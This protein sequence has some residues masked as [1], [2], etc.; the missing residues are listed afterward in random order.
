MLRNI[1]AS[2]LLLTGVDLAGAQTFDSAN[3]LPADSAL[4]NFSILQLIDSLVQTPN[5]YGFG[6][7]LI[8]RLGFNSN[9][10]AASRTL[11]LS[12]FGLSPGISYYHKSGLYLDA[13]A[14][15]SQEYS[16][17]LYLT[18]PSAGYL[19]T[20]NK[21]T[22]N[23]EYSRY[24]YSFS[25]STYHLPYT[26]SIGMSNFYELKPF[27]FRFDYSLYFGEKTAHRLMPGIMLNFEK[28]NWH[29]LRRILFYPT[30]NVLLGNEKWQISQYI[31]NATTLS[32]ARALIAQHQPLFRI[33]TDSY[34]E[35]GVLNYSVSMPLSINY[36]D[37]GFLLSY[38]YNFQQVLPN[39]PITVTNSGYLS[40]SITRYFNFKSKTVLTDL[41][42]LTK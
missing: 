39:E 9:V 42:K 40:L 14:Y 6:S 41:M 28:R 21:W 31:P 13:T 19:K 2:F 23:F 34:N 15:W 12:Q 22:M 10:V 36:K 7:T 1:I 16:P 8:T 30:F 32:E 35:F 18:I 5:S 17:Y 3:Q 29:G 38:V 11:G 24:V 27:L 4:N 20:I 37:W 33:K 26:N 25:D